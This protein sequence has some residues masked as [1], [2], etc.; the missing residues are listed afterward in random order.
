MPEESAASAHT[1]TG[2]VDLD[3]L[4][5][6]TK[7]AV[8]AVRPGRV[9]RRSLISRVRTPANRVIAISAPAGYGKSTLLSEWAATDERAIAWVSLERYDDDPAKLLTLLASAFVRATGADDAIIDNMRGHDESVLGRAAPLLAAAVNASPA[10]FVFVLDDLHEL[11]SPS[12]HDVLGIVVSGIPDGSQFVAASRHA[13]PH[14]A[15]LRPTGDVVEVGVEDL[16]LDSTGVQSIFAD[17]HLDL[18]SEAAEQVTERTEGWPAGI[19][20]AAVV[21]QSGKDVDVTLTGDDRY[22]ADYLY[23]E[24]WASL[25]D[26]VQV[27]LRRTAILDR[28]SA[29]L[30]DA[31]LSSTGSQEMLQS[32]EETNAFLIPLD[33]RRRWYRYHS[34]FREF[35]LAE[36]RRVEPELVPELHA[37]AGDWYEAN[38]S[39]EM[40][41]EHFLQTSQRDR[42]VRLVTQAALMTYQRGQ[43]ETVRRWLTELGDATVETY[44]PLAVLA[45]WIALISGRAAEADRWAS[46]VERASFSGTPADGTA[47]F[48]SGRAMLRSMMVAHGT[49]AAIAD[50]ELALEAE[51]AWSP[52]RDQALDLAAEARLYAGDIA[53]AEALFTEAV[54]VANA[55]GK[56]DT[57]AIAHAELAMIAMDRNNWVEAAGRVELAVA[58]IDRH[59]LDDYAT[60]ALSYVS[61]A[62]L[63]LHRGDLPALRRDLARAMRAR[64]FCTYAAPQF[65]VRVRVW[66]AKIHLS[67]GDQAAARHLMREVDELLTRRPDLGHFLVE[68]EAFR[69]VLDADKSASVGATPLSPAELRLLPYLQTHLS[70]REIGDRLFLSRNTISTEVAAIYRKLGVSSRSE[71]VDRATAVGLL[72]G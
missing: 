58:L 37:R 72:G 11:T 13:Q 29:E 20:L 65:A 35:L 7:L 34:L 69:E 43:L 31:T 4:L 32:L 8:P 49:A 53:G 30:V 64:Q 54:E 45:G 47:S 60:A 26:D 21:A 38:G 56:S 67:I 57:G 48:D 22:V 1:A 50:A 5:L 68:V 63:S 23:R 46:V 17:A 27:F 19:Y 40:A 66:L 33:R 36:L 6:N 39:A 25:R 14:V 42:G 16:A 62:R 70:I 24:S 2:P 41:S 55:L 61:A 9:S 59:H 3:A 12:C 44:P 10:P 15:A 28:F 71:A 51:P 18:T 52:W